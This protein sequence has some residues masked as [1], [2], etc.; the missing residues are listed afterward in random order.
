MADRLA[1][2]L[3]TALKKEDLEKVVSAIEKSTTKATHT[4]QKSQGIA[5]G[6]LIIYYVVELQ[7]Q[8]SLRKYQESQRSLK[9]F[10]EEWAKIQAEESWSQHSI[11]LSKCM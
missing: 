7:N 3:R 10:V 6:I 2:A 1:S 9:T 11:F 4:A 5:I 8:K